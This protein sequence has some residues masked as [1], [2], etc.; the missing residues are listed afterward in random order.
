MC[1]A[2]DHVRFGP[3]ADTEKTQTRMSELSASHRQSSILSAASS[4]ASANSKK[5]FFGGGVFRCFSEA[6]ICGE[7]RK[8]ECA[9]HSPSPEADITVE[10]ARPENSSYRWAPLP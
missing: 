1:S 5:L 3:E 9:V 6:D 2:L 4:Q 7:L 8:R 10:A